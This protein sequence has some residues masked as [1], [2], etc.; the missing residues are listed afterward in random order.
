MADRFAFVENKSIIVLYITAISE[1]DM[2]FMVR[3]DGLGQGFVSLTM[4]GIWPN[5]CKWRY[6]GD[7]VSFQPKSTNSKGTSFSSKMD[8][9]RRA[10]GDSEFP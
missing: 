6:L 3:Q 10:L 7:V 4:Q 9:T 2:M 8:A 1:Y 5:G